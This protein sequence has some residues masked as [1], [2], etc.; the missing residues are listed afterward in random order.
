MID[1]LPLGKGGSLETFLTSRTQEKRDVKSRAH[2]SHSS[3]VESSVFRVSSSRRQDR[4]ETLARMKRRLR[5]VFQVPASPSP[6]PPPTRVVATERAPSSLEPLPSTSRC[7]PRCRE[8]R[9]E[10][11]ALD[12][13]PCG[14]GPGR[15]SILQIMSKLMAGY[16]RTSPAPV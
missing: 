14:R 5:G 1:M 6:H 16:E 9:I 3:I 8:S 2:H 12:K 4:I 11:T 10:S 7:I 15:Q 13:V